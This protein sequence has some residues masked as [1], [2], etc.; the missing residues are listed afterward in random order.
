MTAKAEVSKKVENHQ[1]AIGI[2]TEGGGAMTLHTYETAEELE[3]DIQL[4][5]ASAAEAGL[6][7]SLLPM[8]AT[9]KPDEYSILTEMLDTG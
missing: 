9:G 4:G 3:A 8:K 6:P 2:R 7:F 1:F 5:Q